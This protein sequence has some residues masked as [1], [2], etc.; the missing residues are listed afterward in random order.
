MEG[1]AC[2]PL[3][4][5]RVAE[6]LPEKL[7]RV[8]HQCQGKNNTVVK[9]Y[10]E[11]HLSQGRDSQTSG[12]QLCQMLSQQVGTLG[13]QTIGWC[14]H[15]KPTEPPARSGIRR[16]KGQCVAP[17]YSPRSLPQLLHHKDTASCPLPD[18]HAISKKKKRKN[19]KETI[20]LGRD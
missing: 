18:S 16:T 20:E 17:Q 14:P 11:G 3:G 2:I 9:G 15:G 8:G 5:I 4:N 13:E 1:G 7:V 19:Q 10:S 12:A 6:T